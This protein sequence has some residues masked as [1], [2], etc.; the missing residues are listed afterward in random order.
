MCQ[1]ICGDALKVVDQAY[2]EV[3]ATR[4]ATVSRLGRPGARSYEVGDGQD[5]HLVTLTE[6]Q[7]HFVLTGLADLLGYRVERY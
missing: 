5:E 7:A 3:P 4:R 1:E 6:E 2:G